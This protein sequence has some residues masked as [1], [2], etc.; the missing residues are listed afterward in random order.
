MAIQFAFNPFTGNLDEIS[1]EAPAGSD[2]EIQFNDNG[3]F[4]ADSE[5]TFDK[6]TNLFGLA[7]GSVLFSGTTGATPASGAGTRFMWIP[8]KAAIRAGVVTGTDWDDLRVEPIART[9]GANAPTFEKWYDD[10][11][12]EASL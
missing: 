6:T 10:I 5:F 1:V 4:G 3:A 9:T 8:S 2:K 12:E 11:I 7:N